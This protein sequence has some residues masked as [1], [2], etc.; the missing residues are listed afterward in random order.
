MTQL[1]ELYLK[2]LHALEYDKILLKLAGCCT[3]DFAKREAEE[4]L[5]CT[6]VQE[7]ILR[8][9][10]TSAACSL[11]ERQGQPSFY[12]VSDITGPLG[13]AR[14][15]AALSP[16]ELRR[17]AQVLKTARLLV[18]YREAQEG[19]TAIDGYFN[20]LVPNR[21]LEDEIFD[22]IL[23]DTEIS[24]RASHELFDIRR[25]ISS[26]NARIREVLNKLIHSAAYQKFLQ[27]PII[28]MRGD[29]FVIPV[30]SEYRADVPGLVHDTSSSGATVFIEPMAVV[31]ANNELKTLIGKEQSEIERILSAL[32]GSV[33]EF[34]EQIKSD[35]ET[36]GRL[37]LIF[38]KARLSHS[39]KGTEPKINENGYILLKRAR[40]PLI[41]PQKV[42]PTT[43][44]L[45]GDFDTLVITG[46]NTGGKTVALK[47]IGLMCAMA[48][49]GLHLP[50]GD[51]STTAVFSD[52]FADIGD[53]QSIEQSLS[54]FSAHMTNIVAMMNSI[55]AGSLAL[56]DELGAGTDPV[57]G[58]ALA[59]A[60]LEAAR[61]SGARVA[62]TTHYSELKLFALT[63]DGVENAS[64]EFDV[65][66]LR[67]TYKLLIGVPGKSNAF[68]ISRRLGLSEG[69]IDRAQDRLERD[70]VAFEDVISQ[71]Q[72]S[73][74]KIDAEREQAENLRREIEQMKAELADRKRAY[75]EGKAKAMEKARTEA[76]RIVEQARYAYDKVIKELDELKK[77]QDRE[78]LA[79]KRNEAR[80]SIQSTLSGAEKVIGA[81]DPLLHRGPRVDPATLKIGQEVTVLNLSKTATVET[82]PDSD[83]RMTVKAGIVTLSVNVNDLGAVK[84]TPNAVKKERN[85]QPGRQAAGI[86]AETGRLVRDA[87]L[88]CDLRGQDTEGAIM[89]LDKFIDESVMNGFSTVTAIHGKGTGALRVA[90]HQYLK[91]N[92]SVKAYRLGRYGEGEDGVTVIELK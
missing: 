7:A 28:S 44:E 21:F 66:T 43:I 29:R 55:D 79:R 62:A 5:P 75:A 9:S 8:Q 39:M 41:D 38:A 63:T 20:S 26:A 3:T 89:T 72:E 12:G 16:A 53:E 50:A 85:G 68:A 42:V 23:S 76:R 91:S 4:L 52:I 92:R 31:E 40:H 45:G 71:M 35:W 17:V 88:E 37:D 82:L 86:A 15:G 10:H 6:D 22:A 33:A 80:V 2:S 90:V 69:I 1:S 58:A 18:S 87:R 47:T 84:Q 48:A 74:V 77:Q 56:F 14:I 59:A 67:P 57:E 25:R 65:T 30:R 78:D 24:D 11:I 36:I 81:T 32:S 51:G 60:I 54:T 61:A 83:G 70:N 64:C 46:P 19:T 73:R 49:S 27:E 13:R 34:Y